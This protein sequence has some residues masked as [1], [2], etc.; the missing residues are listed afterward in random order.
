LRPVSE[1]DAWK[2]IQ[3][4]LDEKMTLE[5]H[6]DGENVVGYAGDKNTMAALKNLPKAKMVF[7]SLTS[8]HKKEI[9][10]KLGQKIEIPAK[11]FKD[12][13]YQVITTLDLNGEDYKCYGY[14]DR[15]DK[16]VDEMK[17]LIHTELPEMPISAR[18]NY[19]TDFFGTLRWLDDANKLLGHPYGYRRYKDGIERGFEEAA[20]LIKTED[21]Y[22]GLFL[23]PK[24]INKTKGS[25][26]ITKK[27]NIAYQKDDFI[28]SEISRI[29]E[30]TFAV[31]PNFTKKS[32]SKTISIKL[33]ESK[34]IPNKEDA[35][36]LKI[37]K[38]KVEISARCERGELVEKYAKARYNIV[39]INSGNYN[40][41]DNAE[42]QKN[43]KEMFEYCNQ[44]YIEPVP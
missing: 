2:K 27:W 42:N 1:E 43:I 29:W 38:N 41:L 26:K 23:Q 5:F 30:Q 24:N 21:A 25:T 12:R 9:S 44:R 3:K 13:E 6:R 4:N 39:Y 15:D 22:K 14:L 18:A 31:K 28:T 32:K 35:Y 36:L 33:S 16:I 40:D 8:D 7:K 19:I 37:S 20:E 10:V 17:T 34:E 11:E